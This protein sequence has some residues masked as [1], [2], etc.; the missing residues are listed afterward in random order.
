MKKILACFTPKKRCCVP[1]ERI[2][3]DLEAAH[4][5]AAST[6]KPQAYAPTEAFSMFHREGDALMISTDGLCRRVRLWNAE[7][8]R[9]S[10]YGC[11]PFDPRTKPLEPSTHFERYAH[12]A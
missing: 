10:W 9:W 1:V 4:L 7:K 5:Q 6:G 11:A 12:A 3:R 8:H 2:H